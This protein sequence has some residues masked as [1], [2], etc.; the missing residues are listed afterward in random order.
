LYSALAVGAYFSGHYSYSD[1][2]ANRARHS[3]IQIT[4]TSHYEVACALNIMTYYWI[5]ANNPIKASYYNSI[6]LSIC[7]KQTTRSTQMSDIE[8]LALYFRSLL[9]PNKRLEIYEQLLKINTP[10]SFVF[11]SI[12]FAESFLEQPALQ[13]AVYIKQYGTVEEQLHKVPNFLQA[14]DTMTNPLFQMCMQCFSFGFLAKVYLK[15]N[16]L[17][18]AKQ[19]ADKAIIILKNIHELQHYHLVYCQY[20]FVQIPFTVHAALDST[21]FIDSELAFMD[22]A[23]AKGHKFNSDAAYFYEGI[24]NS[25]L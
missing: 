3:F 1:E 12:V 8:I 25:Q 24:H 5:N 22:V 11:S 17:H 2:F 7:N 16:N 18:L 13:H 9:H 4:D 14:S 21:E 15:K 19:Y 10:R 6:L 20:E 23:K